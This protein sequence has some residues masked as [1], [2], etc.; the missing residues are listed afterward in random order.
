M[1][2]DDDGPLADCE[3]ISDYDRYHLIELP[4]T[5][6]V[7]FSDLPID[8][9]IDAMARIHPEQPALIFHDE[10]LTFGELKERSDHLAAALIDGGVKHGDA[11]GLL[12]RRGP[13]LII[14]MVGVLKAGAAYVPMLPEFPV[15][16]LQYM[17]EVSGVVLTLCDSATM[18]SLPEGLSCRFTDIGAAIS[19]H[20]PF[21]PPQNRTGDDICFILFTSGSTGRPKGVMLRHRSVCNLMAVLYPAL[22]EADGGYLCAANSIFDIFTTETLIAMAF[23]R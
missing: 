23:G 11:V 1:L 7:P 20:M 17:A 16:R 22:S 18:E 5:L 14:G 2:R 13:Q 10:V 8:G 3:A 6:K 15:S 21:V 12:C 19:G 9:R 4:H